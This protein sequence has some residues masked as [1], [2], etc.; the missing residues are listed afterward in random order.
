MQ[1]RDDL[2]YFQRLPLDIKVAMTKQR[3][4]ETVSRYGV[5]DVYVSFSGGKD[6]TVLLD[7]VRKCYPTVEA[8]FVN[9]GLEY[10]EIQRFV[11]TFNNVRVI[12]PSMSFKAVISE[13][14]YP[15]IS[16]E[17]AHALYYAKQGK[18]WAIAQ[19][20][21][22]SEYNGK[23]PLFT[24]E[25]YYG[26]INTDFKISHKCCD[27]IKKSPAH[28]IGKVP[29]L[30]TQAAES[31]L[32]TKS[33]LKNGCNVFEGSYPY[34]APL[35]FWTTQD[36]LRYIQTNCLSISSVYGH[37]DAKN[38]QISIFDYLE[39]DVE[40][41]TTGCDRTGCI[42]CAFGAHKGRDEGRFKRLKETH[43]KQWKYCIEGGAYDDNGVWKPD[44]RGLG[45]RH[46]FDEIN[47]IIGE[48]FI[49]YE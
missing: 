12:Y 40:L 38:D 15:V 25:K 9:T 24:Y 31:R 19:M 18:E 30:G 49:V 13:H 8:V 39:G 46:V 32:R 29:F 44:N 16:K 45:M 27:I 34:S 36:I 5:D 26:L 41:C 6:S 3:I 2:R 47:R 1:T 4:R 7:I 35:S 23:K 48:G 42:Y 20:K 21:G 10:P 22:S 28:S 17:V 33:W 43:P 37:I 14:G 11:S